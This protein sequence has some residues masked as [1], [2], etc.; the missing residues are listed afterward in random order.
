MS[1]LIDVYPQ[2]INVMH[3]KMY[4]NIRTVCKMSLEYQDLKTNIMDTGFD[5]TVSCQ[6][7][8]ASIIS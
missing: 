1:L 8:Q 7:D 4:A 3:T 2:P 6:Y 5:Y